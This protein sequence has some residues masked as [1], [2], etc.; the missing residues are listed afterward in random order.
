MSGVWTKGR[1]IA[2]STG[3]KMR[4]NYLQS[5]AVGSAHKP[6]LIAGFFCDGDGGE[7]AAKANAEFT[8]LAFNVANETGLSP[9]QLA[10][11]RNKLLAALQWAL[12]ELGGRTRYDEDVADQQIEN[13]YTLAHKALKNAKGQHHER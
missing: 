4:D 1:V 10:D 8:A 12:D 9:R 13:C 11:Q 5:W 2:A 7:G 6:N 3:P